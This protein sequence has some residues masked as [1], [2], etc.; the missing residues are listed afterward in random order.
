M[1]FFS[2]RFF[3]VSFLLPET[4]EICEN[5]RFRFTWKVKVRTFVFFWGSGGEAPGFWGKY[6][7]KCMENHDFVPLLILKYWFYMVRFVSKTIIKTKREK[8]H[9]IYVALS[10]I[11]VSDLTGPYIAFGSPPAGIKLDP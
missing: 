7:G 4:G 11:P 2:F 1:I 3:R 5:K 9:S 10:F 6:V 8:N